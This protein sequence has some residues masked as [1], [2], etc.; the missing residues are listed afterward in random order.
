MKDAA[1][2][3]LYQLMLSRNPITD[4]STIKPGGQGSGTFVGHTAIR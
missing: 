2:D 3:V 1:A 4:G